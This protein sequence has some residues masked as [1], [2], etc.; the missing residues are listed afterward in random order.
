MHMHNSSGQYVAPQPPS[1]VPGVGS[2]NS[3]VLSQTLSRSDSLSQLD[4]SEPRLFPGV[5]SRRRAGSAAFA[6]GPPN[7]DGIDGSAN[8]TE[9]VA[10]EDE[11][12]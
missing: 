7:E 1:T 4:A 3:P 12:G 10:E 8:R 11:E 5:V 2:L 9:A 6:M